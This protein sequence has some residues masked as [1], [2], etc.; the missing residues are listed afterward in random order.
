MAPRGQPSSADL[1]GTVSTGS[2]QDRP[3][4]MAAGRG[5]RSRAENQR[6][7]PARPGG[8]VAQRRSSARWAGGSAWMIHGNHCSFME[9]FQSI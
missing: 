4:P 2:Q 3:R 7:R 5:R 1:A 8:S 9:G 6:R